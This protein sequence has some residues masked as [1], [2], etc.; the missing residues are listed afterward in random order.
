V[1]ESQIKRRPGVYVA[2]VA[3]F[4]L[5]LAM[6]VLLT[7]LLAVLRDSQRHIRDT[8]ARI[9]GIEAGSRPVLDDARPGVRAIAPTLRAA[10]PLI[11]DTR[12]LIGPVEDAVGNVSTAAARLPQL[13]TDVA[14]I[15]SVA[16]SDRVQ[17][18][19]DAL[20]ALR[21]LPHIEQ[22]SVDLDQKLGGQVP[23]VPSR[24]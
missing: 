21:S 5:L 4:G 20:P 9:A 11:R 16:R 22:L 24:R 10:R 7:L 12:G 13:A 18:G 6:T 2:G 17:A 3:A 23:A 1:T 8:D 14:S 19:L 15:A